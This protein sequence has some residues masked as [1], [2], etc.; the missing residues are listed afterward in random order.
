MT[1][2]MKFGPEWLRNMSAEPSSASNN[3]AGGGVGSGGASGSGGGTANSSSYSAH[4]SNS[5]STGGSSNSNSGGLTPAARNMFPEYRYGRE[6]MLSLFD[7]SCSLP[8]ILPT[9]KKLFIDKVQYPLALTPSSEDDVN[10]QAPTASSSRPAWLQRSTGGFGTVS[11]GAGRGG[12][13]DRGRMRGKSVYHPIFQRPSTLYDD[14]LPGA[15]MKPERN[16][17]ERNGTGDT[18]TLGAAAGGLGMDWNGTPSSSPRKEFSSHHRN[19]ENWRRNRSEDGSGDGPTGSGVSGTDGWRSGGG[20]GG[21]ANSNHRWGR[22]TSWRDEEPVQGAGLEVSG[23]VG[24]VNIQRSFS[25]IGT[26]GPERSGGNNKMATGAP[27][28]RQMVSKNNQS[29]SSANVS[30]PDAED[31]LPEWAMENPSEVGGTFD[32]SGAFHG[33]S[34]D[35]EGHK[36]ENQSRNQSDSNVLDASSK[37]AS[38]GLAATDDGN[39]KTSF[40][41]ELSTADTSSNSLSEPPHSVTPNSNKVK[42]PEHHPPN[43]ASVNKDSSEAIKKSEETKLSGGLPSDA[44]AARPRPTTPELATTAHAVRRA[45]VHND[46][47]DRFKDVVVEV[48]KLLDDEQKLQNQ[49]DCF[50]DGPPIVPVTAGGIG[51]RFTELPV[52]SAMNIKPN[53]GLEPSRQ[54]PQHPDAA[55]PNSV[56]GEL[57]HQL[58]MQQH[59]HQQQHINPTVVLPPHVMNANP[60]DLW[61]YRDPQSNVQG[62]FSAI[63]MTEWYRAGYFNENLS[64]RRFSDSRFRPLGELIKLC[65]G[66]M[67]FTHSHLLPSPVDL[68]AI[69]L[70][71]NKPIPLSLNDQQPQL[72]HPR[73]DDQLKANVTAAA[74]SLADGLK[75]HGMNHMDLSHNLTLRFQMMQE[76]YIQH[77]EYQIHAELSKNECFQRM[78]AGER[79]A[80]VRRKVQTLVLPEYLSSL[81]GLGNSLAALNPVACGQLNDAIVEQTKKQQQQQLF[82]GGN[83]DQQQRQAGNFL[84]ADDFILKTQMMH[85]QAQAQ[86]QGHQQEPVP[87]MQ[88]MSDEA[89]KLNIMNEYNLRMLLRGGP[90]AGNSAAPQPQPKPNSN[91]YINDSPLLSAQSLMMPMWMPQQPQQQPQ[92]QPQNLLVAQQQQQLQAG[93]PW[94]APTGQLVGLPNKGLAGTLWDV[95]ALEEEQNQQLLQ[96]KRQLNMNDNNSNNLG[97]EAAAQTRN[98]Q[99]QPKDVAALM[100]Q[101]QGAMPDIEQQQ[102]QAGSNARKEDHAQ[103]QNNHSKQTVNKPQQQISAH[104]QQT[105]QSEVKVSE[106]ERRREQAEEKRRLKEER[107]R[108]QMEEEKR[109]ALQAEEERYRQMQ[110]EK[111]RQQQIQAQRRKAL[112]GNAPGAGNTSTTPKSSVGSKSELSSRS[113][114]SIAP[115]SLQAPSPSTTGPGLAE[116]Q[117]A[118]RRER[119][120][121]QQRQQEQLDKQ[122]RAAAAAADASDALLKWQASPSPAPVMSLAEIQAEEAKR[123]SLELLEQQRR[124]E[125]EQQQQA[126]LSASLGV[127]SGLSNIWSNTKAWTTTGNSVVSAHITGFWDEPSTFGSPAG[128]AAAVVAA[129]LHGAQKPQAKGAVSPAT[130]NIRKSQTVPTMQ[131]ALAKNAA[132][133]KAVASAQPVQQDKQG[134]AAPSKPPKAADDKKANAKGQQ[135][136]D[137]AANSKVSEYENEFTS[138]C[139]KSLANMSAKVD[140]PTFVT[141]LQDLEAPYEVKDYVRIYLG[142]GKESSDF[143]K[144]FLERR[145]KYKNLQRAQNAHN[146]DMCK[147]APA[148]TPSGNDNSDSKNKQKKVKKNKMTKMDARI[149]G[150]S[151]TAAEGRINVGVRDYGDGP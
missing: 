101:P 44:P 27:S 93:Q 50:S 122:M 17:T 15:S 119:R 145:S 59:L 24:G 140:V 7:R 132:P 31:N 99:R 63:E 4:N 14:G 110:E 29:W 95:S 115:W 39:P 6:E 41:V 141:F 130:R 62:P 20:N 21:F 61:F 23:F 128:S 100:G 36:I 55:A 45:G 104:K 19:M 8:Q 28:G 105:K 85:Q 2:S 108:Q 134:K 56:L 38:D 58:A 135:G 96:Q 118:E 69:P 12:A 127:G 90:S 143:A 60:N 146:D 47:S 33:E 103:Q 150:F 102:H 64:V 35:D 139:M 26:V 120:A 66:N 149:L 84:E 112:L 1:D 94:C 72:P 48:E 73:N 22:S 57:G 3:V 80:L 87:Q 124:R 75:G 51:G 107:K 125:L 137:A 49:N 43:I 76:Q 144:Q 25:T 13:V 71:P 88:M 121:D 106:E 133:S 77:Q 129:G 81:S 78:T 40:D 136:N 74:D 67:P 32:A 126:V 79:E 114:S 82:A 86:E 53:S 131:N 109:R 16:W 116:I 113:S 97:F 83:G 111:E 42:P 11:R 5:G 34:G 147:P 30:G 37:E 142:E 10:S 54:Q 68:D 138:W 123:L 92:P 18:S 52:L 65:H 9:F 117:K 148:I 91:D 70:T 98:N 46:I 89:N 151:V